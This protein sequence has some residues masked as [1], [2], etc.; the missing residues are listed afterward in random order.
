MGED[1]ESFKKG[2]QVFGLDRFTFGTY[3]EYKCMSE[4][5]TLATKPTNLTYEEAAAIPY[6]GLLALHFLKRGNIQSGQRILVYGASGAVGTSA[7]QIAK[8]FGAEVTGVC[9]TPNLDLVKF[10]GAETAVDYTKDD[11][12]NE[13]ERY[14]FVFDAVGKRKSS[15]LKLLCKKM[16]TPN[17]RYLSVDDGHPKLQVKELIFLKELA[18]AGKIEPVVDRC[19]RLE[20]IAE[21]HRYVDSGHKKGNVAI[22]MRDDGARETVPEGRA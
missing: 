14:D 8:F 2:D 4:D 16:L 20:K 5:G 6:G 21:A 22:T 1:V 12:A 19:Y 3:A 13:N 15:R 18:E 11:F 17:G 7:V 10:L 9:S